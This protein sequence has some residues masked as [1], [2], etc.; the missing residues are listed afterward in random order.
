MSM[1]NSDDII[2]NRNRDLLACSV[3]PQPTAPPAACPGKTVKERKK[4]D[5]NKAG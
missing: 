4:N 3:M 1:K 5:K 2:G